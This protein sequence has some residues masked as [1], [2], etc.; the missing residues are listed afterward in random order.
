MTLKLQD[1]ILA[2]MA[3]RLAEI[4]LERGLT[5][6]EFAA[7]LDTTPKTLYRLARGEV[8]PRLSTMRKFAKALAMEASEI[9]E[10]ARVTRSPGII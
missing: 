7:L 10:F 1:D 9:E 8:V 3:K 2:A 4:R 5:I 6:E